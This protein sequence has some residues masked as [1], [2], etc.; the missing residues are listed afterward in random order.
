MWLIGKVCLF[1]Y[2]QEESGLNKLLSEDKR[3]VGWDEGTVA[4]NVVFHIVPQ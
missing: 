3:G 4:H 1:S 2:E